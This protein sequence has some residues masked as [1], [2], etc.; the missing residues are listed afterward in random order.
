MKFK[1]IF[2]GIIVL[3]LILAGC[4]NTGN[5][6]VQDNKENQQNQGNTVFYE[7]NKTNQ[8]MKNQ[9]NQYKP[10]SLSNSEKEKI[11]SSINDFSFKVLN[12][13]KD[14]EKNNFFSAYNIYEVTDMVYEGSNGKT[15]DEFK[16]VFGYSDKSP[17]F[18]KNFDSYLKSLENVEFKTANGVWVDK[19]IKLKEDY[20][21]KVSEEFNA[22]IENVDFMNNPEQVRESINRWVE[23]NTEKKIKR[24][25]PPGSIS[26]STKIVVGGT[27]Y[28]KGEWGRKY[29]EKNV[30]SELFHTPNKDKF[31]DMITDENKYPYYENELYKAVKID[32]KGEKL[33]MVFILPKGEKGNY[34]M[35]ETIESLNAE[36]FSTLLNDLSI[37]TVE[38]KF[39]KFKFD[40][41]HDLINIL[42]ELG[43]KKA[44]TLSAD[45]SKMSETPLY[46][47]SAVHKAYIDVNEEGTEAAGATAYGFA[48]TC[49]S[50]GSD[51]KKEFIADH[52][53]LFFIVDNDNGV[54]L[55]SG[56]VTDPEYKVEYK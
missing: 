1:T 11:V 28:F 55:F 43:V 45:F 30:K 42:K 15:K 10:E 52:P 53:F 14:E 7:E 9:S 54:I 35:K 2:L 17:L 4:I 34:K 19:T 41:G 50:C 24:L 39:P 26:S 20:V 3:S 31:V 25:L 56:K 49:Y 27:I 18:I 13:Y 46:L 16:E 23:K 44:F 47:N 8:S 38:L 37:N 21:K 6:Q 32:Y 33:S 5:Q 29:P 40:R 48:T 12:Y 51:E 36:T 22:N